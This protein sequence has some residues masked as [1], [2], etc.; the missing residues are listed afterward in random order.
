MSERYKGEEQQL[1]EGLSRIVHLRAY[2][3][4]GRGEAKQYTVTIPKAVAHLLA[5]R[6]ELWRWRLTEEGLL[7][8]PADDPPL[9]T[10]AREQRSQREESR[11]RTA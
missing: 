11:H 6:S 3:G 9:P 8:E 1:V 7:L 2:E 10:W 4:K 5:K